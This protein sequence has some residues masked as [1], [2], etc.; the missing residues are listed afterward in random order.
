MAPSATGP[1]VAKPRLLFRPDPVLG[2]SLSPG[3]GVAVGFRD[4]VIQRIGD[5]GWRHVPGTGTA[6][7][8][9][10]AVYGCS[11]T[12]GTGLA[13]DETFVAR[14]QTD[15]PDLRML[16][17]GVGGH[18][19]RGP[20]LTVSPQGTTTYCLTLTSMDMCE[21][22]ECIEIVVTDEAFIV[23]PSAFS[24]NGNGENDVFVPIYNPGN[25][26]IQ[27]FLD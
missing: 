3:H 20:T 16:N 10:V 23:I 9:R 27:S 4:G 19:L 2:W 22:E 26:S 17:R 24:P 21:L 14:L 12:Y 7:G 25:V 11:F 18:G 5:D 6:S 1:V 13:D 15:R 8:P